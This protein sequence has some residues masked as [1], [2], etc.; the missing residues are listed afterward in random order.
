M[1][2]ISVEDRLP[3]KY[4]VYLAWGKILSDVP[5]VLFF[6]EGRWLWCDSERE[7]YSVTHW[8]PLPE[9]PETST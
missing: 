2:R 6:R 9:P 5:E 3:D 7:A 1:E 4:N 8:M